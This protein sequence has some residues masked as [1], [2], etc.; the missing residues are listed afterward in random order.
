MGSP[1]GISKD[2]VELPLA[3]GTFDLY[4]ARLVD[5]RKG[6]GHSE[7]ASF[8]GVRSPSIQ[9]IFN[10]HHPGT[11]DSENKIGFFSSS[12]IFCLG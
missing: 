9:L 11:L 2:T 1:G 5:L 7:S 8:A 10:T 6:P 4:L 3:S 12:H